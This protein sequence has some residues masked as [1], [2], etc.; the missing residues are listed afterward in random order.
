V[1]GKAPSAEVLLQA[2]VEWIDEIRPYLDER[3]AFLARVARAALGVVGREISLGPGVAADSRARLSALLGHDGDHPALSEELSELLRSGQ[4]D[5][6]MPGL[7]E[8]LVAITL[9]QLAIDQPSYR[10]EGG[11]PQ[12][13]APIANAADMT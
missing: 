1:N 9:N 7:R 12:M 3:N 5:A 11:I 2:V 6:D 4:M 8:A 13:T 10:A